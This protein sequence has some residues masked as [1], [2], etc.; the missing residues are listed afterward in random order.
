MAGKVT[1]GLASHWPFVRLTGK[2]FIYLRAEGLSKGDE[3]PINTP[4][5][6]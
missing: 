2:W 1:I 6:V 4:Q 3:H 5:G